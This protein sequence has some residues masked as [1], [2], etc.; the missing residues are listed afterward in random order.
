MFWRHASPTKPVLLFIVANL[1]EL[2]FISFIYVFAGLIMQHISSLFGPPESP[3]LQ[4]K[5]TNQISPTVVFGSLR[6]LDGWSESS[7]R[8]K[9]PRHHLSHAPADQTRRC[10][11]IA[12]IFIPSLQLGCAHPIPPGDYQPR[13]LHKTREGE[14]K[15]G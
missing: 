7:R 1:F 9:Q 15:K 4:Q 11:W 13:L 8:L 6:P 12:S 5:G 2:R 10:R 3:S 14:K